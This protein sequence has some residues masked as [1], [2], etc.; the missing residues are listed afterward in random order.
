MSSL[1]LNLMCLLKLF[2]VVKSMLQM[3]HGVFLKFSLKFVLNVFVT[4]G[5]VELLYHP[6]LEA[7]SFRNYFVLMVFTYCL[8]SQ[9]EF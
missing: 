2:P 6:V 3:L 5:V 7:T 9:T 4:T 1:C 8:S